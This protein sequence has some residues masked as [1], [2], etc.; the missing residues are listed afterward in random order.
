MD[1]YRTTPSECINVLVRIRPSVTISP[2]CIVVL[3]ETDNKTLHITPVSTYDTTNTDD[4]TGANAAPSLPFS[5]KE[6][7]YGGRKE[8]SFDKIFIPPD[9]SQE[10]YQFVDQNIEAA[11]NGYNSTVLAYGAVGYA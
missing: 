7:F 10:I 11:V 8:F 6:Q 9:N 1:N 4:A 5:V 2:S 3:P